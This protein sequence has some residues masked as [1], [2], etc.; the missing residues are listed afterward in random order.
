MIA[1][2]RDT[3]SCKRRT[4]LEIRGVDG[5]LLEMNIKAKKILVGDFIDHQTATQTIFQPD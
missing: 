5:L 3:F 4:D 2:G 1:Y